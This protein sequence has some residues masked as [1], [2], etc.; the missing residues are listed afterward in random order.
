MSKCED[1]EIVQVAR[2]RNAVIVTLDADFHAIL[3]V[4]MAS[5]PS[6]IRLRLQGLDGAQVAE[7]VMEVLARFQEELQ[8][9]CMITVKPRKTTCHMLPIMGGEQSGE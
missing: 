2:E 1:T 5:R 9:G 3:A 8:R 6:T 7:F 4:S